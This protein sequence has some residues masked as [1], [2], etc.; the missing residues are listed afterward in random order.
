MAFDGQKR[1]H[2]LSAD[3]IVA[4]MFRLRGYGKLLNRSLRKVSGY[5]IHTIPNG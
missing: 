3:L 5:I 2:A 4:A 1:M